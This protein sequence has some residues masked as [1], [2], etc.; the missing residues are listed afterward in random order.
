MHEILPNTHVKELHTANGGAWGGIQVDRN[1]ISLLKEVLTPK[2][3]EYYMQECPDQW[4]ALMITFERV[5]S[6]VND[7]ANCKLLIPLSWSIGSKHQ[8]V[9][10]TDI[11]RVINSAASMGVRFS[12]GA[13]I[14]QKQAIDRIFQPVVKHIIEHI[15]SLMRLPKVGEIDYLLMVGGFG[16]CQY[17][18]RKVQGYFGSTA[19]LLV[20]NEAQMAVK[21]GAVLFGHQP[22]IIESRISRYTYGVKMRKPFKDGIHDKSRLHINS[23]GE[24]LCRGI[25]DPFVQ[26]GQEVESGSVKSVTYF[27]SGKGENMKL[28]L[29]RT[30]EVTDG[31]IDLYVDSPGMENVALFFVETPQKRRSMPVQLDVLFGGTEIEVSA[32]DLSSGNKAKATIDF[33]MD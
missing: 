6:S 13:L 17:L 32:T 22:T 27:T 25:F 26:R 16:E 5:K 10:G 9:M 29:Y 7:G 12:N 1:F 11:E 3:M 24:H 8:Q 21:K 30:E 2:F 23:T 15:D 28:D 31:K 14:L 19:C 20:P 4:L 33:L 18:Q